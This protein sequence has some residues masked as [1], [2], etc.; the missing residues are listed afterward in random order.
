MRLLSLLILGVIRLNE[1]ALIVEMIIQVGV[2]L[3][4]IR[5]GWGVVN[6]TE[7]IRAIKDD[8]KFIY[9]SWKYI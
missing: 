6:I 9:L 4:I 5:I 7:E 8:E 3:L 2:G 1:K